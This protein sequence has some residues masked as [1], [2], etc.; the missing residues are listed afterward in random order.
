M[1][2][3]AILAEFQKKGYL[4]LQNSHNSENAAAHLELELMRIEHAATFVSVRYA[5]PP[6]LSLKKAFL[7]IL[8]QFSQFADP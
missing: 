4:F 6:N 8:Y 7:F 5:R 2:N 1:E 3:P